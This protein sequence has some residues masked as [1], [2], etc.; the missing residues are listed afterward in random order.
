MARVPVTIHLRLLALPPGSALGR[1]A[2]VG[3]H[4]PSLT[5]GYVVIY[6][7]RKVHGDTAPPEIPAW[8]D[9][10]A[11]STSLRLPTALSADEDVMVKWYV[12]YDMKEEQS[13]L[14]SI[15]SPTT[16]AVSVSETFAARPYIAHAA[17]ARVAIGSLQDGVVVPF[18]D[19]NE[20]IVTLCALWLT[21]APLTVALDKSPACR[22]RVDALMAT[23]ARWRSETKARIAQLPTALRTGSS[24]LPHRSFIVVQLSQ[25]YVPTWLYPWAVTRGRHIS[26]PSAASTE[27]L[28]LSLLEYAMFVNEIFGAT[29]TERLRKLEAI[30]RSDI[31]AAFNVL[32]SMFT[33]VSALLYAPDDGDDWDTPR[34]GTMHADDCEG[35]TA[36]VMEL[37]A[38]FA[39]ASFTVPALVLLQAIDRCYITMFALC[40]LD[41]GSGNHT[42]HACAVKLDSRWLC[43]RLGVTYVGT[44]TPRPVWL[45]A[46]MPA[47]LLEGT[48]AV[49]AA[50]TIMSPEAKVRDAHQRRSYLR[51]VK[52]SSPVAGSTRLSASLSGGYKEILVGFAPIL[53]AGTRI[54][55]HGAFHDL[56]DQSDSVSMALLRADSKEIAAAEEMLDYMPHLEAVEP[57]DDAYM[58]HTE[59]ESTTPPVDYHPPCFSSVYRSCDWNTRLL[60][61]I[62]KQA[63]LRSCEVRQLNLTSKTSLVCVHGWE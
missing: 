27:R 19:S 18:Y 1:L 48:V 26:S 61:E 7:R 62:T 23:T 6:M 24:L 12:H 52:V 42:Y 14:V 43:R 31:Y 16:A 45:P 56:M 30:A 63:S 38:R 58:R 34:D 40:T 49:D 47:L 37:A 10:E 53:G 41:L 54:Q 29:R 36:Q 39:S 9:G 50:L 32:S 20:Q 33:Y 13:S 8:V 35:R 28:F 25:G 3:K 2:G 11:V 17:N 22:Q 60:R 46:E 15:L 51:S 59:S 55:F 57:P 44:P 21:V 5:P 4:Y